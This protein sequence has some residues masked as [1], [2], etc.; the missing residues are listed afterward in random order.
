MKWRNNLVL[1]CSGSTAVEQSATDCCVQG[2]ESRL[3]PGERGEGN[4]EW[5]E[6]FFLLKWEWKCL[7]RKSFQIQIDDANSNDPKDFVRNDVSSKQTIF[8]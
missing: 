7:E 1:A 3:A 2:F 5:N 6:T 4:S 8:A